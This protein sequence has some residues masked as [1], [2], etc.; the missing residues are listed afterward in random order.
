MNTPMAVALGLTL[1]LRHATDADHVVALSTLLRRQSG[2]RGALAVGAIWGAG[3]TTVLLAAGV[4]VVL[5]G[6]RV[7]PSLD[8]YAELAV[9]AMLIVLGV[10]HFAPR[11]ST[12]RGPQ[13]AARRTPA[14][15][16]PLLIGMVHG[17]AGSA[18]IA[19][20]ALA[21]IPTRASAM[22]YLVLFGIGTVVG[23]MA[24]TGLLVLPIRYTGRS[25][26]A[27][28]WLIRVASALSLCLG[29]LLA[30]KWML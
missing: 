30:A 6:M 22:V 23:M 5:L 8:R 15:L 25:P 11:P 4:A 10:S 3:H 17:L 7:P 24:L 14:S 26:T 21:T 1:G 28:V 2:I 13:P 16:R 9:A 12:R 18:G 20:I 29:V 27:E 19:L